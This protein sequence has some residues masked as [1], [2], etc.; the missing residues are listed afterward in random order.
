[1]QDAAVEPDVGN[2]IDDVLPRRARKDG[3]ITQ[4]DIG[5]DA[6]DTLVDAHPCAV[7]GVSSGGILERVGAGE[8]QRADA[9]LDEGSRTGG[10]HRGIS[11]VR[12]EDDIG[13][14]VAHRER[15]GTHP[16]SVAGDIP[17][18]HAAEVKAEVTGKEQ[19]GVA[20]PGHR[21]HR[22]EDDT[23][24][25]IGFDRAYVPIAEGAGE[26][27]RAGAQRA[28][29]QGRIRQSARIRAVRAD[30][31][32]G[33]VEIRTAGVGAGADAVDAAAEADGSPVVINEGNRGVSCVIGDRTEADHARAADRPLDV[34]HAALVIG[35][36]AADQPKLAVG[37]GDTAG[38]DGRTESLATDA[39]DSVVAGRFRAAGRDDTSTESELAGDADDASGIGSDIAEDDRG[40]AVAER[41]R[42]T[43]AH[44]A[45]DI[46]VALVDRRGAGVR[47]DAAQRE[48]R[49][50]VRTVAAGLDDVDAG[51]RD[52]AL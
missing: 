33:H 13:L 12:R 34:E 37:D 28:A 29:D 49:R 23:I 21:A 25:A 14:R 3:G 36:A 41:T 38:D 11:H 42:H 22:V 52:H 18:R 40:V 39:R 16:G 24:R 46:E 35:G 2:R 44:V 51:A 4:V 45:S 30:L 31:Q 20:I 50:V 32:A 8:D 9:A 27:E 26:R 17:G 15:A 7:V 43:G 10:T 19:I 47:V 5:A 48:G 1:M 6:E